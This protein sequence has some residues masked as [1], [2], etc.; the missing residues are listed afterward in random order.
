VKTSLSRLVSLI[1]LSTALVFVATV[2]IA[3]YI[4]STQ[5]YFNLGETMIYTVALSLGPVIGCIAG[6]LGSMMADLALGY[7]HYAPATLVIK[8]AEGYVVG[9]LAY[10]LAHVKGLRPRRLS[11]VTSALCCLALT[12]LGVAYY[13]G[14]M[15]VGPGTNLGLGPL[16]SLYIPSVRLVVPSVVWLLVGGLALFVLV[17]ITLRAGHDLLPLI[18]ASL[19]GGALMVLGYF[20]YETLILYYGIIGGC[21]GLNEAIA[22]ALV[23]VP[24]NVMQVLVGVSVGVPVA[25]RVR[26]FRR[27][28]GR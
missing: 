14:V 21:S 20:V 23:E 18:V 11:F 17:R 15:D 10:R 8:G 5:G 26:A 27:A 7:P 16:G 12:V 2:L 9:W 22:A 3:A 25:V 24:F 13:S 19:A 4:P 28:M 1:A 6:G